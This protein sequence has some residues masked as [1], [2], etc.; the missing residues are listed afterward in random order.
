MGNVFYNCCAKYE[1][2]DDVSEEDKLNGK[3]LSLSKKA[4]AE[5]QK[6][7]D[8]FMV[9]A[10]TLEPVTYAFV[11]ESV[12]RSFRL[13]NTFEQAKMPKPHYR[14]TFRFRLPYFMDPSS[15]VTREF[16]VYSDSKAKEWF[17]GPRVSPSFR[18]PVGNIRE[19]TTRVLEL[20]AM[21]ELSKAHRKIPIKHISEVDAQT[22]ITEPIESKRGGGGS[23]DTGEESS[24]LVSSVSEEDV[25]EN[26]EESLDG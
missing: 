6:H 5:R 7:M 22:E 14:W 9:R 15:G 16:K 12:Q 18:I 19:L 10:T 1:D 20:E 2:D 4:V 21:S 17:P 3:Y 8:A 25:G 24:Q 23:G 13:R 11:L 26:E